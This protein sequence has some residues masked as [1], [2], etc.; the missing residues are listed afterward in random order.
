MSTLEQAKRMLQQQ[1]GNGYSAYEHI[2]EILLK[3]ISEKPEGS[4]ELME[5]LSSALKAGRNG[6]PAPATDG[7]SAAEQARE[8]AANWAANC[9]R[10]VTGDKDPE[11]EEFIPPPEDAEEKMDDIVH[12]AEDLEWAGISLGDE[13][14]VRIKQAM[15]QTL[16]ANDS[17]EKIQFFG[18]FLG[19]KADYYVLQATQDPVLGEDEEGDSSFEPVANQFAYYA[20]NTVGDFVRLPNVSSKHVLASMKIRTFLT[21]S[22]DAKVA[23]HPPFPGTEAHLLRALIARISGETSVAPTYFYQ[24]AEV[25]DGEVAQAVEEGEQMEDEE[26]I[27]PNGSALAAGGVSGFRTFTAP[28]N[29]NGCVGV[30]QIQDPNDEEN[31][32]PDPAAPPAQPAVRELNPEEWTVSVANTNCVLRSQVWP[33]HV[34]LASERTATRIYIGYGI[35]A[36]APGALK[37]APEFP[38]P[39]SDEVDDEEIEEHPDVVD[40]PEEPKPEGEGEEGEG[41]GGDD[42]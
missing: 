18:K 34:T 42:E 28:H 17:I 4:L 15:V 29:A 36:D 20:S 12:L 19:T 22:L 39:I 26:F 41:E 30:P 21:G 1:D 37:W 16:G 5:H 7:P 8:A 33:G 25:E 3:L 32:I 38:E 2:S 31:Q 9:V 35:R 14:T 11:T 24:P 40:K 6:R 10:L 27:A 13:E 23:A